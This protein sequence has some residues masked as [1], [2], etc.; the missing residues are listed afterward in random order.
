MAFVDVNL[1]IF[2]VLRTNSASIKWLFLEGFWALTLP[3]MVQFVRNFH[4]KNLANENIVS[5]FFECF[6]YLWKKYWPKICTFDPIF[7]SEDGL[8]QKRFLPLG[9]PNMSKSS[10]ISSPLFG[11]FFAVKRSGLQVKEWKFSI[12]YF[13][14]T[15]PGQLP[16]KNFVPAHSS[17]A[18]IGHKNHCRIILTWI[19][20]FG[21]FSWYHAYIMEKTS[22]INWS[23]I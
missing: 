16:A 6:N 17:F 15:I 12:T 21:F 22:W 18:A 23:R 4:Q 11:P 13:T 19:F 9:Y 10:S 2:K 1:I 8:N 14:R 7:V 5:K 3:N 20:K